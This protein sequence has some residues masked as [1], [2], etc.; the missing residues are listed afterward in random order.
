ML[1]FHLI[2]LSRREPDTKDHLNDYSTEKRLQNVAMSS[3]LSRS[4]RESESQHH[5]NPPKSIGTQYETLS[6]HLSASKLAIPAAIIHL[7]VVLLLLLASACRRAYY[8]AGGLSARTQP[9]ADHGMALLARLPAAAMG[10][11]G[12]VCRH[13]SGLMDRYM[14]AGK[15]VN[16]SQSVSR[17]VTSPECVVLVQS[18]RCKCRLVCGPINLS[19]HSGCAFVDRSRICSLMTGMPL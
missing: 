10:L 4:K 8:S 5:P 11:S 9:I 15:V 19:N 7:A 18:A 13:V 16:G 2:L 14:V 1:T 12:L 6:L 17:R 3:S